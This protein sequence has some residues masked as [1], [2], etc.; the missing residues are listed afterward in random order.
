MAA[1]V[2]DFIMAINSPTIYFQNIFALKILPQIADPERVKCSRHFAYAF[3]EWEQKR[4]II[5]L[6]LSSQAIHMAQ[7]ASTKLYTR[8]SKH[9]FRYKIMPSEMNYVNSQRKSRLSDIIMQE[10]PKGELL[11]DC[12][13]RLE[14]QQLLKAIDNLQLE[15]KR[16][17]LSH[18][19]LNAQNVI[20]DDEYNLYPLQLHYVTVGEM[21]DDEYSQLREYVADF[22]GM[23]IPRMPTCEVSGSY[24][25]VGNQFEGVRVVKNSNGYGYIDPDG[26]E[27]VSP[28]FVWAGS[29]KEGRA[30]VEMESG[31]A[32]IIWAD[33]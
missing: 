2:N 23:E 32:W 4:Y 26:V 10:I 28:Q 33:Q 27:I 25:F 11:C 16:L 9:L 21:C 17:R 31:R 18:S 7:Q 13:D 22:F 15:F 3:I 12:I 30:E 29:I 19:H 5:S 24:D 8:K 20:I 6:P 14:S 1:T